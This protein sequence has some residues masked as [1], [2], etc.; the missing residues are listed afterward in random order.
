VSYIFFEWQLNINGCILRLTQARFVKFLTVVTASVKRT[1]FEFNFESFAPFFELNSTIS[2][3][4]ISD[5]S[6]HFEHN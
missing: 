5:T 4:L 2:I 3:Q 6:A 1:A